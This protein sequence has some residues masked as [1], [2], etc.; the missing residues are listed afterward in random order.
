MGTIVVSTLIIGRLASRIGVVEGRALVRS[1]WL[2][3]ALSAAGGLAF[4]V[5]EYRDARAIQKA[6][7]TGR[8]I[9][10]CT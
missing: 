8:S 4:F 9:P 2:C 1:T 6:P 10:G 5:I 3:A 7:A